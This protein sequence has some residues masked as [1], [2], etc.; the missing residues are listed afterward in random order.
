MLT[1]LGVMC[2]TWA[3]AAKL[4]SATTAARVWNAS[5]FIK[6]IDLYQQIKSLFM[7]GRKS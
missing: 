2:M 3:A 1:A 7:L 4:P 6:K 5:T